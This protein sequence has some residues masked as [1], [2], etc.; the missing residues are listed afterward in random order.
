VRLVAKQVEQGDRPVVVVTA[1]A[2]ITDQLI[3][4][5]EQAAGIKQGDYPS[6]ISTLRSRFVSQIKAMFTNQAVCGDL[7]RLVDEQMSSLKAL[8]AASSQMQGL[9]PQ[10][11]DRITSIGELIAIQLFS[12]GLNELG[13]ESAAV[14][15][16]ELILTDNLFTTASPI[17][18]ETDERLRLRLNPMIENG[19]IPVVS[20]FIGATLQGEITTLGRGG[21]D[22]TAAILGAALNVDQV[23]IW[24]DVE[25]VMTTDPE[26]VSEARLINS[27][28]YD[29]VFELAYFGAKVLHPKAIFPLR[30]HNIPILVKN[31]FNPKGGGTLI[32]SRGALDGAPLRAVAGSKHLNVILIKKRPGED[33]KR[34]IEAAGRGLLKHGIEVLRAFQKTDRALVYLAVESEITGEHLSSVEAELSRQLP[35]RSFSRIDTLNNFSMV[36]AVGNKLLQNQQL[37]TRLNMALDMLGVGSFSTGLQTSQN[38]LSF[39]V[40]NRFREDVVKHFHQEVIRYV[41]I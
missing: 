8:C 39:L 13:L 25:G 27:I 24:T 29:E 26:V 5:A 41:S 4:S 23:W 1:I 12:M 22:Y 16:S 20:G 33:S 3:S 9:S 6:T 18:P 37:V 28:S 11:L 32:S 2:G 40:P 15:A 21:G 10:L 36:T 34:I 30:E 35:G 38:S 7:C 17:Q 14:D 31:I 19:I